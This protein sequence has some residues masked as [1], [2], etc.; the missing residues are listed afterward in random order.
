MWQQLAKVAAASVDDVFGAGGQGRCQGCGCRDRRCLPWDPQKSERFE[1]TRVA[2][3]CGITKGSLK[4]KL[5]FLLPAGLL[6]SNFA[7]GSLAPC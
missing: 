5:V 1:A 2:I 7:R 4:N 6:L 3:I